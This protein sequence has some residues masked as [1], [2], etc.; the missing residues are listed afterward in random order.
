[1]GKL[2]TEGFLAFLVFCGIYSVAWHFCKRWF[3]KS[4][5]KHIKTA[6]EIAKASNKYDERIDRL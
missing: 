4:V 6:E 2:L 3:L 1:M 5:P